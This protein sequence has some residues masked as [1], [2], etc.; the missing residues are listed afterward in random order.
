MFQLL[1]PNSTKLILI[2]PKLFA[3]RLF[4]LFFILFFIHTPSHAQTM[5]VMTFNIKGCDHMTGYGTPDVGF[6]TSMANRVVDELLTKVVAGQRVLDVAFAGFQE[7]GGFC[8]IPEEERDERMQNPTED[9]YF[10]TALERY[11]VKDVDF[12]IYQRKIHIAPSGPENSREQMIISKYPFTLINETSTLPITIKA[13][14]PGT[15]RPVYV[16]VIHARNTDTCV[17]NG[18]YV[19][20]SETNSEGSKNIIFLGDFNST[21][22]DASP[23][24]KPCLLDH[25]IKPEYTYTM[26]PPGYRLIDYVMANKLSDWSVS[27]TNID[28]SWRVEVNG[29][30]NY[31]SD[32]NPVI[33][34]LTY[35]NA[36]APPQAP[37]A[38]PTVTPTPGGAAT[39]LTVT[40]S[41]PKL[42]EMSYYDG[43]RWSDIAYYAVFALGYLTL[44]RFGFYIHRF[45][46]F[47]L[48]TLVF[49]GGLGATFAF[50]L[51]AGLFVVI[52]GSF[53]IMMQ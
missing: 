27:S 37:T 6:H 11:F 21:Y 22:H 5:K 45:F 44:I 42:E 41:R 4:F 29:V 49:I 19:D 12:F 9:S 40:R 39:T 17:S 48:L 24:N 2:F 10:I 52:M 8:G 7:V 16:S 23:G 50:G 46:S 13:T 25:K 1:Q 32:H 53:M 28:T 20:Q 47:F 51:P 30:D 15:S 34:T 43:G 36:A 35:A 31:W 14:V 38:T 26:P 33:A 3:V 18:R